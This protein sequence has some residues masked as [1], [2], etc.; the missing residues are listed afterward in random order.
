VI[1]LVGETSG[2]FYWSATDYL[3]GSGNAWRFDMW[4]G[5]QNAWFLG[6]F[7]YGLALRTGEVVFSNN[8]PVPEPATVILFGTGL[9]CLVGV[10]RRKKK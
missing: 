7:H 8:A 10:G 5:D 2:S 9:V 6:G 1:N 3:D 4:N